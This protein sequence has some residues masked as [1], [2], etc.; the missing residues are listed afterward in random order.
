MKKTAIVLGIIMV[1]SK[2]LG[3]SREIILSYFY[4][5]SY[6]SDAYLI[7]LSIPVA[8]FGIVA[9][10][11]STGYIP[12][13]TNVEEIKG[14]S[15]ANRFT[16]N[17][18]NILMVIC[19]LVIIGG[20]IFAGPLVKLFASGF[21]GD[22]LDI[23]IKFT[24]ISLFGMFFTGLIA[25]FS[26]FLQLKGRY[27]APALIGFPFNLVIITS[28]LVSSKTSP[29]IMAVGSL[30][31]LG[32][33]F[34]L[35]V[36]FIKSEG[37]NHGKIFNIKD[38]YI[39]K[40]AYIALPVMI[41]T[42]VNQVNT[43]VDR[44][45]ASSI[46]VGGIST[47]NYAAKLSDSILG[48][49]VVTVTTVIYP[50]MSRMAA[51]N[52]M[53]G[54]KTS[55]QEA[56]NAINILIVPATV[57]L[58]VFSYPLVDMIFNRGAFTPAALSM[59]SSALFYYSLGTVGYGLR[60]ILFRVFYSL[61]DTKTPMIN[62]SIAVVLNIVLNI[63]LSRYMGVSGLALAT[64]ISALFATV[65]LFISLKKKVGPLGLKNI[66]LTFI[67]VLGASLL[68][69]VVARFAYRGLSLVVSI[70]IAAVVYGISILFLKI[71]EVDGII[72]QV[73][74]RLGRGN[75]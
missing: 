10:G 27:L 8:L 45:L 47:L 39:K 18:I 54:L 34:L 12:M 56:I 19:A 35:L 38:E 33:Q 75:K 74:D 55:V 46:S 53:K 64:S 70:G 15:E 40:M 6:I 58:M 44:T 67:K 42:S 3:F 52:D 13:Y 16:N 48:L 71:D 69:G 68:M 11:I 20:M 57:G 36:P 43:I 25:I 30:M 29:T 26:G 65:L 37:Y 2:L 59:T 22:T 9:T 61:Q 72:K 73:K 4:G 7:S 66:S 5:A 1:F 28:I 60:Q 21:E 23:A 63:I 17:L 49:F 51:K 41:G 62:A 14:T 31:A 24:R 32:S 50:T